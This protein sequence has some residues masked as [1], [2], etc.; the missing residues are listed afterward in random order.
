MVE[1]ERPNPHVDGAR[2]KPYHSASFDR[3]GLVRDRLPFVAVSLQM[4]AVLVCALGA[5]IFS[6]APEALFVVYG[7]A[8]AVIPNGLFALRLA[9]HR[10]R[11]PETYPVVFFVGEALKVLSSVAL[12]GLA[13]QGQDDVQWLA[14]LV[15]WIVA[16]KAPL[17]L[18]PWWHWQSRRS[19]ARSEMLVSKSKTFS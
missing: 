1:D 14:L 10:G 8:S 17:L 2:A 18:L 11:P 5:W 12:L 7:G 15:G 3:W 13:V 9:L 19:S 16:L 6:G 4:A